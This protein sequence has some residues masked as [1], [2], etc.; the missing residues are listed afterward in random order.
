MSKTLGCRVKTNILGA[1]LVGAG[2]YAFLMI[3]GRSEYV[4]VLLML[5]GAHLISKTSVTNAVKSAVTFVKGL[6]A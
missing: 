4:S 1:A 6:A 5:V 3:P 2:G